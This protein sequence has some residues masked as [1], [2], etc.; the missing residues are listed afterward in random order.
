MGASDILQFLAARGLSIRPRS[1][2]NLEVSPRRL[3]TDETRRLILEHKAELLEE[4]AGPGD[5]IAD[6]ATRARR[7]RLLAMLS[8]RRSVRYAVLTDAETEPEAVI[9]ALAIRDV[10]TCELRIARKKWDG[11]LFLEMLERHTV[12]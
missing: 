6:V 1:D 3:L 5:T 2:G 10:G 7:Q 9:V 8:E 4:L 12:H 11:V